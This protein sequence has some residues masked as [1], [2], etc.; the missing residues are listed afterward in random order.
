MY[1]YR[2][3]IDNVNIWVLNYIFVLLILPLYIMYVCV[4]Q[5]QRLQTHKQ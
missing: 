4:D 1:V 3:A 2:Y 5:W